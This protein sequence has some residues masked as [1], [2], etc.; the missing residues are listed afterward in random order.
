MYI[1]AKGFPPEDTV[2]QQNSIHV[3]LGFVNTNNK[4]RRNMELKYL[5]QAIKWIQRNI[6]EFNGNVGEMKFARYSAHVNSV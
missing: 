6:K 1:A 2:E 5:G 4:I 3:I